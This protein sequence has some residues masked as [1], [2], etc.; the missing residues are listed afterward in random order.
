[1]RRW[2]LVGLQVARGATDLAVVAAELSAKARRNERTHERTVPT[3]VFGCASARSR[4]SLHTQV[5]FG[6]GGRLA[7]SAGV[8][9]ERTAT[10]VPG[11]AP[12]LTWV[13]PALARLEATLATAQAATATGLEL[14]ART[15]HLGLSAGERLLGNA[16]QFELLSQALPK[17]V[18]LV[19]R[20]AA[21]MPDASAPALLHA[22]YALSCV[23]AAGGPMH[24]SAA[25]VSDACARAQPL[26]NL[27]PLLERADAA[28]LRQMAAFATGAYGS[29]A[30]AVLRGSGAGGIIEG[31]RAD[32]RAGMAARLGL[33]VRDVVLFEGSAGVY[34]PAH[35]VALDRRHGMV[36]VALRGT[37]NLLD[38]LTNLTCAT[39]RLPGG[40]AAHEGML[41]AARE[42]AAGP[43]GAAVGALTA[44]H[45]T[46]RLRVT[47]HSQGAGVAAL[48]V[49]L[50]AT[51]YPSVRGFAF[52]PPC[53][54]ALPAARALSTRFTSV[55]LGDDLIGRLSLGSV[56][57]LR[58]AAAALAAEP[59]LCTR[60]I[61]AVGP[62]PDD[63]GP[64][65]PLPPALAVPPPLWADAP[66]DAVP[67]PPLDGEGEGQQQLWVTA[68]RNTLHALMQG[69]KLYPPGRILWLPASLGRDG[70][71]LAA[72]WA[73]WAEPADF[74]EIHLSGTMFAVRWHCCAALLRM[75]HTNA[76]APC[77]RRTCR[78]R[79]RA[80]CARSSRPAMAT[81]TKTRTRCRTRADQPAWGGHTSRVLPYCLETRRNTYLQ[82]ASRARHSSLQRPLHCAVV[83]R[84]LSRSSASPDATASKL[85]RTPDQERADAERGASTHRSGVVTVRW[86]MR[87]TVDGGDIA[88]APPPAGSRRDFRS[89]RLPSSS[90][91]QEL[92]DGDAATPRG[93]A[94]AG[95]GDCGG[96]A[97]GATMA[98]VA[99][100]SSRNASSAAL[101]ADWR[102]DALGAAAAPPTASR[103]RSSSGSSASTG[104][105]A[106]AA[107]TAASP[108]SS[109]TSGRS[110]SQPSAAAASSSASSAAAAGGGSVVACS[111]ESAACAGGAASDI[112]S[113]GGAIS[114]ALSAAAAAACRAARSA[115]A[116][117]DANATG[118][119]TRTHRR[120]RTQRSVLSLPHPS[121]GGC[122]RNLKSTA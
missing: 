53:V 35:F 85:V 104:G 109:S 44:E 107:G 19:R 14:S 97:E 76:D 93:E 13:G 67:P 47:G 45:P 102:G 48:L 10:N 30:L 56:E 33:P 39:A 65:F 46:F 61:A 42:L 11:L 94:A 59:R 87:G 70:A 40:G 86:P 77:C 118:T 64:D 38:S 26:P 73:R 89:N 2:G 15:V 60:I 75:R 120:R 103:T 51:R 100:S 1:M 55:V 49:H 119:R 52:A 4:A 99:S 101:S 111:A 58:N 43:V 7:Q 21:E 24:A 36:V 57:D 108:L 69:E 121:V 3:R 88:T 17:I 12:A 9:V 63:G 5:G 78:T 54:L 84:K 90:I 66:S 68:L 92:R 74:C 31:M 6:L 110:Q 114:G 37:V 18:E 16:A 91:E 116:S 79:W 71:V 62:P 80:P 96:A 34:R 122:L 83:M 105:A 41:A 81:T 20:F 50:W 95:A 82:L 22:L 28:E 106:S 98:A 23:Q 112:A 72:G 29:A 27:A 32:N 117:G 115:S 113:T 8:A 25:G